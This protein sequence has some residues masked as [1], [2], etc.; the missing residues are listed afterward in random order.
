MLGVFGCGGSMSA[1]AG[2]DAARDAGA[3]GGADAG[4]NDLV[5]SVDPDPSERTD[6]ASTPPAAGE[7]RAKHVVCPEELVQGALA[8]GRVGDIVLENARARCV[9]RTGTEAASTI[10]GPA[11][12]VI[13][14]AVQGGPDSLKELFPLFDLASIRPSAIEVID[15]GG[16]GEARVRVLFEDAPIGLVQTVIPGLVRNLRLRGRIDYVLRADEQ[17]LRLELGLTT[18][19]GVASG[20]APVGVLALLG[21][22]EEVQPGYGL[23]DDDALGGAGTILVAEREDAAIAIAVYN[24]TPTLTRVDTIHLFRGPRVGWRRGALAQA[25]VRLGVGATAA[26]AYAS[27]LEDRPP[28]LV[29]RGTPGDRV[30]LRAGSQIFLRSRIGAAGEAAIPLAEGE[31]ELRPGYGPFFAAAGASVTHGA[32][33]TEHTLVPAAA[34]VLRVDATVP[35]DPGA[36]VRVTVERAGEDLLRFVATGPTERRLPPGE[37][38]VSI[39]HGLEHDA[40]QTDVTLADGETLLLAPVLDRVLDTSGWASVD[41]HLH[42]E[43]STDSTHRVEDALRMLAAEGLDAASS[44]DHDFVTDYARLATIA[45]VQDRLLLVAGEEVST[46]VYGHINGYPLRPDPDRAGAGAVVWF[47]LAPSEVFAGLRARGDADLGGALVQINHPRLGSAAFFS[48]VGLDRDTGRATA[49]PAELSLPAGTDLDD[50][51]FEVLEIWNGYTRGD[52][53]ASFEDYLA[54]YAAGRPFAM[55]GNSDSHRPDLPAGSPRS[56]VRVPDDARGALAWPAIAAA[57]RAREVT[58]AAGLF[59]TAELAGPRAGDRVPVHVRVQAPPWA[60]ADRLRIYAGR[61]V[62]VDQPIAPGAG[63]VRLDA[64]IDVPLM[65]A[66]FIVVRADGT[67]APRPMQHF[68]SF[69]ATNPLSVP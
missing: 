14:A 20:G 30:E 49:D 50:F 27:V 36:P 24:G 26:E 21:G 54:L 60:R 13:D 31:Y 17:A 42:S 2:G 18:A 47:E 25:D 5:L 19:E 61:D 44:S 56:F 68:E 66:N 35:G 41:L 57:L 67:A 12:G 6:C 7:A 69:G 32:S 22:A 34:A 16:D 33:R 4:A 3:D 48:A 62:A 52:N 55:V 40:S 51:G 38:R 10:G 11:G 8:M 15:A 65:G 28:S 63:G 9:V 58:V 29:V 37:A 45:D 23:V 53:E 43:L 46:T 1:D 64:T 39:S 59:V